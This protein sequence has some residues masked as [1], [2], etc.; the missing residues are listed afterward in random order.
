MTDQ[1]IHSIRHVKT[2]AE[3]AADL[4]ARER[5]L[6][7]HIERQNNELQETVL[8]RCA[9]EYEQRRGIAS[10]L[11]R[12][13]PPPDWATLLKLDEKERKSTRNARTKALAELHLRRAWVAWGKHPQI[14][15]AFELSKSD[16]GE[17][18]WVRDGL[19]EIL[20]HLKPALPG[21]RCVGISHDGPYSLQYFLLCSVKG[22]RFQ[23][24]RAFEGPV[25]ELI[26]EAPTLQG[27]LEYVQKTLSR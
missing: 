2:L 5:T 3:R 22:D 6:A 14:V 25:D 27:A 19:L 18:F 23:I 15:V 4:E 13:G 17:M 16:V 20:P 7:E 11:R 12:K 21:F 8:Q 10:T 9:I 24:I 1:T 26:F